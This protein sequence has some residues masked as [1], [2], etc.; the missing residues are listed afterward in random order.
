MVG[1]GDRRWGEVRNDSDLKWD[2]IVSNSRGIEFNNRTFGLEGLLQ[3]L[4]WSTIE[5][6]SY[7]CW[8]L[9]TILP[10]FKFD[11][12]AMSLYNINDSDNDKNNNNNK[13]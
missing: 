6:S 1:I 2:K 10:H 4:H 9:L 13:K 7:K 12:M 5:W 3:M 11:D 8:E